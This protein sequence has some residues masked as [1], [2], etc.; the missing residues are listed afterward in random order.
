MAIG[1]MRV[2]VISGVVTRHA[3]LGALREL[4]GA[5]DVGGPEEELGPVVR[6]ERLVAATLL[7]GQHIHLTL[8]LGVR[9]DAAGLAQHLTPLHLF[10]L[11]APQQRPDVVTGLAL[12]EELAEHLHTVH[13][14]FWVGRIPTIS[15]SSPV[16]IRP[17]STLPVTTVPR[18]VIENTSSIGIR[19][20]LSSSRTG[21]GMN[22]STRLHQR[23]H[24][25]APPRHPR[26]P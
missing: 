26:A 22:A 12:I 13:V 18:P 14:V 6:E 2:T 21:S 4:N 1:A 19:N 20:G 17:C 8:E 3:H 16:W 10:L 25:A 7:L 23:Q 11:R 9:R 24:P 5:G 15:T